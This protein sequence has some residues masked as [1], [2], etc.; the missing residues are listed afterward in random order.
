VKR[1]SEHDSNTTPTLCHESPKWWSTEGL[2]RPHPA[3]Q[4]KLDQLTSAPHPCAAAHGLTGRKAVTAR[5]GVAVNGSLASVVLRVMK[6]GT[7]WHVDDVT[8]AIRQEL[9]AWATGGPT[10]SDGSRRGVGGK[11][12]ADRNLSNRRRESDRPLRRDPR[13]RHARVLFISSMI[14]STSRVKSDCAIEALTIR[15]RVP[16]LIASKK[17]T[18]C[19]KAIRSALY[20][21]S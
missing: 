14:S 10:G 13:A 16:L 17:K 18:P 1:L 5:D 3:A 8:K 6:D 19:S 12:G 4:R 7:F 9:R 2:A 20:A 15:R 11:G 21:G